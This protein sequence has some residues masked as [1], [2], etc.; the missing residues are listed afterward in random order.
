MKNFVEM[1]S[2]ENMK[3]RPEICINVMIWLAL[4]DGETDSILSDVT[5]SY[6]DSE[7]RIEEMET[8]QILEL[9][10]KATEE[11]GRRG[12]LPEKLTRPQRLR[13]TRDYRILLTDYGDMELKLMPM[14][15]MLFILFLK[16]PEGIRSAEL[17]N[18]RDEMLEIYERISPRLD[19]D[20]MAESI[21]NIAELR[22]N[23]FHSQKTRLSK[24]LSEYFEDP[25]L[26]EYQISCNM[27]TGRTNVRLDRT[28]VSWEK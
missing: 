21:R 28:L 17:S 11:L 1:D 18:Y 16:H 24:A 7:R 3:I 23:N 22:K 9:M 25:A 5:A 6:G 27:T 26:D 8:I 2:A 14:P 12:V 15:K 10:K 4:R 20:A 13:I 19:R